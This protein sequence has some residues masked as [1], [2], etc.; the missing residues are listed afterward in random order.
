MVGK[1]AHRLAEVNH[2]PHEWATR[3][4]DS[5]SMLQLTNQRK[6]L[7]LCTCLLLHPLG[8]CGLETG[9]LLRWQS[10]H[11]QAGV[12]LNAEEG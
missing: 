10:Q 7:S 5:A 11:T 2:P 1:L 9:G 12:N 4:D 8:H 6:E 3:A